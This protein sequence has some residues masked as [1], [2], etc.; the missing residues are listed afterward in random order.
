M[1]AFM[2]LIKTKLSGFKLSC[3]NNQDML[4]A[5]YDA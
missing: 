3:N 4:E 2:T 5:C 1:Y